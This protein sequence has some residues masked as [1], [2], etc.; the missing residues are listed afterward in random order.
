MWYVYTG[1]GFSLIKK[2]GMKTAAK[3]FIKRNP[4]SRFSYPLQLVSFPTDAHF[5]TWAALSRKF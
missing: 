1:P 2:F 5:H 3:Q 4:V